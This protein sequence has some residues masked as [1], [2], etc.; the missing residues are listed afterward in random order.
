MHAFGLAK[1]SRVDVTTK[2]KEGLYEGYVSPYR[3][4]TTKDTELNLKS[5]RNEASPIVL[6]CA[7]DLPSVA[8]INLPESASED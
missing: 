3:K 5:V 4:C 2:G 6:L 7:A 8:L 1:S